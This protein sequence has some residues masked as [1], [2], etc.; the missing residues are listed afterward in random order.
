MTFESRQSHPIT[1][2]PLRLEPSAQCV[3]IFRGE[4]LKPQRR[5][6]ARW[7]RGRLCKGAPTERVSPSAHG[8]SSTLRATAR[9]ARLVA[10]QASDDGMQAIFATYEGHPRERVQSDCTLSGTMRRIDGDE[11]DT[12]HGLAAW[13]RFRHPGELPARRI[14]E[15]LRT[16]RRCSGAM[17]R[18]PGI[19]TKCLRITQ[20]PREVATSSKKVRQADAG[21]RMRI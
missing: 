2:P 21:R 6:I 7:T 13:E 16:T 11:V 20:W 9:Y 18:R 8:S 12:T 3:P 14:S 17:R 19:R 10:R 1:W 5:H 15:D 4:R